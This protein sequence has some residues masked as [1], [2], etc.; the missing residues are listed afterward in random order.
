MLGVAILLMGI[1]SQSIRPS[2]EYHWANADDAL[3]KMK[4]GKYN[5]SEYLVEYFSGQTDPRYPTWI[6]PACD[7]S[8]QPDCNGSTPADFKSFVKISLKSD[9]N[10]FC[11]AYL[12]P[13]KG[14]DLP[15]DKMLLVSDAYDPGSSTNIGN[16]ADISRLKSLA[17]FSPLLGNS[18][19]SL[20]DAGYDLIFVDYS[21]GAGDIFINS[22]LY[23]KLIQVL[24]ERTFDPI[25][26][27]GPSM[28]GLIA[29]VAG[30]Y[31]NKENNTDGVD[32]SGSILGYLSIDSPH[33][34][35]QINSWIQAGVYNARESW[36]VNFWA[37]VFD[38]QNSAK[39]SW[40]MLKTPA[41]WQMLYL[42]Y[43]PTNNNALSS[44]THDEFYAII[45]SLGR[46]S[47]KFPKVAVAYSNFYNPTYAQL[48]CSRS[49]NAALVPGVVNETYRAYTS[50]TDNLQDLQPGSAFGYIANYNRAP[51]DVIQPRM[52]PV[53][54]DMP[55]G[56]AHA[57]ETCPSS[58]WTGRYRPWTGTFIPI[59]SALDMSYQSN[60]AGN[61]VYILKDL[62]SAS[63]GL[64]KDEVKA[65]TPFEYIGY[66][67]NVFS[68]YRGVS[69]PKYM[70]IVFE[71]ALIAE[72]K[73]ALNVLE[74][75]RAKKV[76]E[77]K[78]LR[79]RKSIGADLLLL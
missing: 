20:R 33:Q 14:N 68:S 35:A 2:V 63:G 57:V 76:A 69:Y 5:P 49:D 59:A 32:Y 70:H 7:L 12:L 15:T 19:G 73:A 8:S 66:M 78:I 25:V 24:S 51:G 34:G 50:C 53:C 3:S 74:A 6:Y 30:L 22:A 60:Y 58:W 13:G 27:G 38:V 18:S 72:V 28:G 4:R 29:R 54:Y 71:A 36:Q 48:S 26:I 17:A 23:A 42:H 37:D 11:L 1:A 75:Y 43:N 39:D 40:E 10:Y 77:I 16:T 64:T 52:I 45:N 31:L 55:S 41:T 9:P 56:A 61:V 79:G 65:M 67:P 62:K 21:Q 47:S 44:T 46:H